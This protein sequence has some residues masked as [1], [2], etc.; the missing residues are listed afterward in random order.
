MFL[1][2]QQGR[3]PTSPLAIETN[4]AGFCATVAGCVEP[5]PTFWNAPSRLGPTASSAASPFWDTRQGQLS[6]LLRPRP[7]KNKQLHSG[8]PLQIP[9]QKKRTC[10]CETSVKAWGLLDF[11]PPPCF[12]WVWGL[13]RLPS[14]HQGSLQTQFRSFQ[15][16]NRQ[17]GN[18]VTSFFLTA[19]QQTSSWSLHSPLCRSRTFLALLS[20][21]GIF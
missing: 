21:R 4:T 6:I 14:R 5:L 15:S 9:L 13:G 19:Q 1:A 20:I 2:L 7:W 8:K 3:G 17:A 16:V 10:T 11:P 12:A 18:P